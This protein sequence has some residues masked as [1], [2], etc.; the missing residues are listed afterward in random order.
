MH[1]DY[2]WIV[3]ELETAC[4]AVVPGACIGWKW[5]DEDLVPGLSDLDARVICPGA[6]AEDWVRLDACLGDV[7]RA[8]VVAR[9]ELARLL[10]HTPGMGLTVEELRDPRRYY[11][12]CGTWTL[13]GSGLAGVRAT[14]AA[15]CWD[16]RDRAY[17]L[18]RFAA[19]LMPYDPDMDPPI[20]L[21]GALRSRYPY[22]S[23]TLH[24]LAPALLSAA[25]LVE[26]TPFSGKRAALRYWCE[27]LPADSALRDVVEWLEG[28]YPADPADWEALDRRFSSTLIRVAGSVLQALDL[29]AESDAVP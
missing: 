23:R 10:E 19:Y 29:T 24:Y 26:R 1:P 12:E 17:H 11:P 5:A 20:N 7:H 22:H 13:P 2:R 15:R 21:M 3:E 16:E 28:G 18:K 25:S 6:T 4:R 8:M 14:L 9:P 27:A